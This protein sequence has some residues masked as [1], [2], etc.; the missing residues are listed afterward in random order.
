MMHTAAVGSPRQLIRIHRRRLLNSYFPSCRSLAAEIVRRLL[1]LAG[2]LYG[3]VAPRRL[4]R[5][6]RA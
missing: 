1:E 5:F 6:V 4:R 3:K 2:W